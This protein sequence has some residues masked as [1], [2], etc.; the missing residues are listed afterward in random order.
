MACVV[1]FVL[2][3]LVCVGQARLLEVVTECANLERVF[4][5]AISAQRSEAE[6]TAHTTSTTAT[7]PW[8]VADVRH[9]IRLKSEAKSGSTWV[10]N[11][12]K[13]L[14]LD[15]CLDIN[16]ASGHR[17]VCTFFPNVQW[18]PSGRVSWIEWE[19][20]Q[21]SNGVGN[22]DA[23]FSKSTTARCGATTISTRP[24]FV[25]SHCRRNFVMFVEG[26]KHTIPYISRRQHPNMTPFHV[27][28]PAWL[29]RCAQ[30]SEYQ[31]WPGRDSMVALTQALLRQQAAAAV[32]TV[33]SGDRASQ[34]SNNNDDDDDNRTMPHTSSVVEHEYQE[35]WVALHDPSLL[36]QWHEASR[37]F[38][39]QGSGDSTNASNHS[40][41]SSTQQPAPD[42]TGCTHSS[43]PSP[44]VVAQSQPQPRRWANTAAA[45]PTTTTTTMTITTTMPKPTDVQFLSLVRDPRAVAAS[46]AQY[47]PGKLLFGTRAAPAFPTTTTGTLEAPAKAVTTMN[48]NHRRRPP[49]SPAQ[50]QAFVHGF[51]NSST[52]WTQFRHFWF[53]ANGPFAASKPVE[54]VYDQLTTKVS[55]AAG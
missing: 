10:G 21:S 43:E 5:R 38:A 36:W 39:Q 19:V 35:A 32:V 14:L 12:V 25:G 16:V 45:T 20:C 2:A 47:F 27:T 44:R 28:V 11:L 7:T 26:H 34:A 46:A 41:T 1:W 8:Y 53:S 4:T 17:P 23:P 9:T 29:K 50:T 3:M 49:I 37:E 31:C 40:D 6:A 24:A 33:G 13:D 48:M 51:V 18:F 52:M 22:S 42:S 30:R 15:V 54:V 55:V